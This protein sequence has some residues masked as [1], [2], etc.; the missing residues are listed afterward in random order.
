MG[1]GGRK[2][3]QDSSIFSLS[4]DSEGKRLATSGLDCTIRIW[5]IDP[6]QEGHH[7]LSVISRHTG[8]III[9]I[10]IIWE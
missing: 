4:L 6:H 9:I 1:A 2:S 10:M 3:Q 8:I 7:L 5:S